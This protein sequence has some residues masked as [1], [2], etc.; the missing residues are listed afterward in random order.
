MA[1]GGGV[2]TKWVFVWLIASA[3]AILVLRNIHLVERFES[4]LVHERH[5]GMTLSTDDDL[6]KSSD[7]A[8]DKKRP[9]SYNNSQIA[10]VSAPSLPPAASD[11]I[12]KAGHYRTR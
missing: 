10:P 1:Q 12:E 11:A 2:K 5:E 9:P 8:E 7:E 3:C 6:D 4:R